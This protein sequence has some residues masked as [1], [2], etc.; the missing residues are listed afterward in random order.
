MDASSS[1][2]VWPQNDHLQR[3]FSPHALGKISVPNYSSLQMFFCKVRFN[4][5]QVWAKFLPTVV[6]GSLHRLQCSEHRCIVDGHF[7]L[8]M[9]LKDGF[10]WRTWTQSRVIPKLIKISSRI[11]GKYILT[12][13][14]LRVVTI[15]SHVIEY[16]WNAIHF[17]W[18]SLKNPGKIWPLTK[19]QIY[20]ITLESL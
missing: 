10:R 16:I 12:Q 7:T 9:T 1:K 8:V 4:N 2:S 14:V 5:L 13:Y 20:K 3:F 15:W 17:L 11:F 18:P 19:L 6:V